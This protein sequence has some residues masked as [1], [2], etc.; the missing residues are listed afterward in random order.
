M[1]EIRNNRE[2]SKIGEFRSTPKMGRKSDDYYRRSIFVRVNA[3]SACQ[4]KYKIWGELQLSIVIRS[5]SLPTVRKN[6]LQCP[7][8]PYQILSY[9]VYLL[10]ITGGVILLGL[11]LPLPYAVAFF[12]VF[13]LVIIAVGVCAMITTIVN[14]ADT[15]NNTHVSCL[16]VDIIPRLE[17]NTTAMCV[18]GELAWVQNIVVLVTSAFLDS[19]TTANG[20]THA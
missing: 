13:A 5:A 19:I 16:F 6:G 17:R 18:D 14:P 15:F 11:P 7:W 1:R 3:K 12:V 2:S 20:W 8:H 4:R 10:F 9:I